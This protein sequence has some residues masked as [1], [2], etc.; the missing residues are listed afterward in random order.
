MLDKLHQNP[1]KIEQI[2]SKH[3]FFVKLEKFEH[4]MPKKHDFGGNLVPK[5]SQNGAKKEAKGA[6]QARNGAK[7]AP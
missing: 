3:G 5:G 7:K 1:C 4:R 2:Q 6:E